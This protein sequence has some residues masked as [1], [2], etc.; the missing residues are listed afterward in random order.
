M[1]RLA[2]PQGGN[3]LR[4][5]STL[6]SMVTPRVP[7]ASRTGW[8]VTI[9]ILSTPCQ[10]KME[11][12]VSYAWLWQSCTNTW[13][14]FRAVVSYD[15]V[16]YNAWRSFNSQCKV[17]TLTRCGG[18]LTSVLP[19]IIARPIYLCLS[20]FAWNTI[21][22]IFFR[23]RLLLFNVCCLCDLLLATQLIDLD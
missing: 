3:Q 20:K 17:V 9:I 22:S 11:P 8:L 14:D 18:T 6:P 7:N 23:T 21:G 13:S 19:K 12:V 5:R 4:C 2:A 16:R 10:E 1:V 15:V